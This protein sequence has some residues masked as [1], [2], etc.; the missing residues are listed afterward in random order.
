MFKYEEILGKSKTNILKSLIES[1][2]TAQEIAL[3][4]KLNK[5][6]VRRHLEDLVKIGLVEYRFVKIKKGRP[7]KVYSLTFAGRDILSAKY[8][9]ILNTIIEILSKN[10]DEKTIN[11]FIQKIVEAIIVRSN[12][13][14]K[15]FLDEL[16]FYVNIEEYDDKIIVESKN[17]PLIRVAYKNPHLICELAH[18]K[19][20]S[21]LT[22]YDKIKLEKTI[23]KGEEKCIHI[24]YKKMHMS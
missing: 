7:R 6:G 14:I 19:L 11:E 8:H 23:A 17:C 3:L 24:I 4:L 20:L 22:G 21:K 1:N 18:S 12:V 15:E 5:N 2:K 13:G 16:G 9:L 10:Y